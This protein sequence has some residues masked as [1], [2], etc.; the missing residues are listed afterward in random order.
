MSH[1]TLILLFFS[2]AISAQTYTGTILSVKDGD[3]F[4]FQSSEGSII[5][6]L[7]GID[8]P[9]KNQPHGPEAKQYLSKYTGKEC[10]IIPGKID[11]Y[12]RTIATLYV[13]SVNINLELL[14]SGLAWHYKKYNSDPVY[15]DAENKARAQKL[16]LWK[17]E[18][19]IEPWNFRK[20]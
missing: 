9:E 10:T 18:K 7:D 6:R 17:D 8:C 3:T 16:G 5:V 4:V 2:L 11:K 15:S 13:D 12:G 19:P 20:Q 14:K 1:I